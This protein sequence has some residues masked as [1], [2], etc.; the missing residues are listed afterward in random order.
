MNVLI[1]QSCHELGELWKKHLSRLGM[2]V[3]L[4]TGQEDA[5]IKMLHHAPAIIVLD[6]LLDEGSAFAVSDFANYRFPEAQ[7]IFVTNTSFFSDGSIFSHSS[8]ACAFIQSQ[9]PPEDIAMLVEHFG[10]KN[11]APQ[12]Y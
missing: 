5:I 7:I 10:S 4:A 9:T 3:V 11:M 2:N 1:V 12:P 8:N 6:L